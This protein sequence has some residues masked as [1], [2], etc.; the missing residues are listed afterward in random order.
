MMW[1]L[2]ILPWQRILKI[3]A[4]LLSTLLWLLLLDKIFDKK[5]TPFKKYNKEYWIQQYPCKDKKTTPFKKYNKEYWIR[6][7]PYKDKKED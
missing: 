1:I 7:Y 6:N 5:T 3:V 4:I 2:Y